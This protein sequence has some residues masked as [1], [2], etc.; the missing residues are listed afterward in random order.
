M[1]HSV[2]YHYSFPQRQ[3]IVK[4]CGT[5]PISYSTLQPGLKYFD[6]SSGYFAYQKRA[7]VAVVLG[8]PVCDRSH[9]VEACHHFLKKYSNVVFS[10]IRKDLSEAL[11]KS[12]TR[13][14]Y[15]CEIG[16]DLFVDT[17]SNGPFASKEINGAIK[18]AQRHG[19]HIEEVDLKTCAPGVLNQLKQINDDFVNLSPTK[20]EMTFLN[21]PMAFLDNQLSRFFVLLQNQQIIGFTALD[22]Y[23]SDTMHRNFL[24][25]ILRF[26]KTKQWGVYIA[27]VVALNSLLRE[28]GS[29]ELSLGFC[30]FRFQTDVNNLDAAY[31]HCVR[32]VA[33]SQEIFPFLN[34]RTLKESVSTRSESRFLVSSVRNPW[35]AL[36]AVLRAM[37]V[38]SPR[39]IIQSTMSMWKQV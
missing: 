20:R 12:C 36:Y 22:P 37:N 18:S 6:F 23:L 30:P 15:F 29:S 9:E 34:L 31:A 33:N 21:R 11:T 7:G 4:K 14:L 17:S 1:G 35:W 8:P 5:D 39:R 3:D 28:E 25:N 38:A 32:R 10:Y 19:F 13:P 2:Y 26:K 16:T 24:L 27:T